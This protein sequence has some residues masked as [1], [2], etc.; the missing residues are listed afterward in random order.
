MNRRTTVRLFTRAGDGTLRIRGF[1]S[2]ELLLK[3][4]AQIGVEDCSTD[5]SLRGL[6]VFQDLVGPM[7]DRNDA[8]RYESPEVFEILTRAWC[9]VS[10]P[11]RRRR[12]RPAATRLVSSTAK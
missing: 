2:S 12:F 4:H 3:W 8:A 5:L 9:F 1:S 10:Q 11:H 6:P 7:P